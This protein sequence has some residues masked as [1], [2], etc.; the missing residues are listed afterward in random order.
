MAFGRFSADLRCGRL[1]RRGGSIRSAGGGLIVWLAVFSSPRT[2]RF[3]AVVLACVVAA[4]L[5]GCTNTVPRVTGY[6]TEAYKN[7]MDGCT[8]TRTIV[9]K[10]QV[11]TPLAKDNFCTCVYN[12]IADTNKDGN[13]NNAR[14]PIS[15][16]D[17][18][19][20]EAKVAGG[21]AGQLPTPPANLTKAIDNC[22]RGQGPAPSESKTT[23]TTK[24][25]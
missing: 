23:T 20:Y 19:S 22:P 11:V 14:Y 4:A 21:T 25:Q 7:F 8:V 2:P 16:D 9:D 5:S 6:G 1:R 10:K 3:V 17:L 12:D 18:S 24:P 13:P 15:W